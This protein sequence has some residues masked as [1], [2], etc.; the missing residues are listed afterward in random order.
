[1][2]NINEFCSKFISWLFYYLETIDCIIHYNVFCKEIPDKNK[3]NI[4]CSKGQIHLVRILAKTNWIETNIHGLII[5]CK[6]NQFNT[7]KWLI[8]SDYVNYKSKLLAKDITNIKFKKISKVLVNVFAH[9]EIDLAWW[10]CDLMDHYNYQYMLYNKTFLIKV[11]KS[12]LLSTNSDPLKIFDVNNIELH[13]DNE[14]L[15]KFACEKGYVKLVEELY[16]HG[17]NILID[18]YE[19]LIKAIENNNVE[20]VQFLLTK[21]KIESDTIPIEFMFKLALKSNAIEVIEFFYKSYPELNS[22]NIEPY[23]FDT[24]CSTFNGQIQGQIQGQ[25]IRLNKFKSIYSKNKSYSLEFRT[26]LVEYCIKTNIIKPDLRIVVTHYIYEESNQIYDCDVIIATINQENFLTMCK[27]ND[28]EFAKWIWHFISICKN[29][30]NVL[31]RNI[32]LLDAFKTATLHDSLAMTLWLYKMNKKLIKE[33]LRLNDDELFLNACKNKKMLVAKWL[34]TICDEYFITSN[35]VYY[36]GFNLATLENHF[37]FNTDKFINYFQ[38][39]KYLDSTSISCPICYE[40][41]NKFYIEF[42]NCHHI[43]CAKCYFNF[44]KINHLCPYC[45]CSVLNVPF[46]ILHINSKHIDLNLI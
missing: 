38:V 4:Y 42:E 34:T 19:P 5:A 41:D 18:N 25:K 37:K 35:K 1:M 13:D 39:K 28:L 6:Y 8:M 22:I 23:V 12:D 21:I 20:I 32:N 36:I 26:R 30:T 15:L 31:K 2:I 17:A 11:F 24:L 3:F 27:N 29:S 7:A 40:D 44:M 45:R 33:N 9:G 46:N 14:F 16:Y 10:L 43:F